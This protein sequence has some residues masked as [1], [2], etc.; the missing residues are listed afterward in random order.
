MDVNA[1]LRKFLAE[2]HRLRPVPRYHECDHSIG[3][4]EDGE[5]EIQLSAGDIYKVALLSTLDPDPVNAAYQAATEQCKFTHSAAGLGIVE[6]PRLETDDYA[7]W[8]MSQ[9]GTVSRNIDFELAAGE[10]LTD[11][12]GIDP[13]ADAGRRS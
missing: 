3:L 11:L 13:D 6:Q 7:D 10:R 1:Y 5:L 4:G 12:G 9:R 8:L 2:L